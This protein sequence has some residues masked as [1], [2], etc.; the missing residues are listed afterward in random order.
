MFVN[1]SEISRNIDSSDLDKKI[2][3]LATKAELKAEQNEIKICKHK[4][5]FF[6]LVKV[7]LAMMDDKIF[8]CFYQFAK[9]SKCQLIL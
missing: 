8:Q 4:T 9:L 3:T 6:L 7:T 1:K 5:Q 2:E